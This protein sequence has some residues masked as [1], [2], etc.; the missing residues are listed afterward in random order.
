MK[1]TLIM[2]RVRRGVYG[3]WEPLWDY[4]ETQGYRNR[5]FPTDLVG[6]LTLEF[7][8]YKRQDDI[9][10][11]RM[12]RKKVR[13]RL[14]VPLPFHTV[15]SLD[16]DAYRLICYSRMIEII[17]V[18]SPGQIMYRPRRVEVQ[19]VADFE[20]FSFE[21]FA[22]EVGMEPSIVTARKEA[23]ERYFFRSLQCVC[24]SNIG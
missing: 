17:I 6:F 4:L 20:I 10:K 22:K 15:C 24:A 16:N 18:E 7:A 11:D 5:P 13:N 23:M 8:D 21:E 12:F 1:Q 19:S 3:Y 9:V 2:P 14:G